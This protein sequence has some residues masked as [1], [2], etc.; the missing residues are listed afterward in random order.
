MTDK[1]GRA[2]NRDKVS[3][4]IKSSDVTKSYIRSNYI[5]SEIE[6][7]IDMKNQYRI[8][9]H[10]TPIYLDDCVSKC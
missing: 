6:E 4:N 7:N 8:K 10:L 5:E 3:S 1:F 9:N 2:T